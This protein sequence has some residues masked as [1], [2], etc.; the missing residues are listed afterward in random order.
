MN[1][2]ALLSRP[3]TDTATG[4]LAP[5][6]SSVVRDVRSLEQALRADGKTPPWTPPE[7]AAWRAPLPASVTFHT[8]RCAK[9][10]RESHIGEKVQGATSL[11]NGWPKTLADHRVV[12]S[13]ADPAVPFLVDLP[14]PCLYTEATCSITPGSGQ[15]NV[16]PQGRSKAAAAVRLALQVFGLAGRVDVELTLTSNIRSARGNGGSSTDIGATL[17]VVARAL[18]CEL[19]GA[20]VDFLT[21]ATERASNPSYRGP[22]IFLQRAGV[23]PWQ[24]PSW[25]GMRILGLDDSRA[26]DVVTDAMKRPRYSRGQIDAFDFMLRGLIAAVQ[27]GDVAAIGHLMERSAEI[28]E[29]FLPRNF[30]G[31]LAALREIRKQC[32]SAGVAVSH[33]GTVAALVWPTDADDVDQKVERATHALRECGYD[34]FWNYTLH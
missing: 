24:W 15:I 7:F 9:A 13:D 4:A 34:T 8:P 30:A 29:E 20:L 12:A 26:P 19:Q 21:V 6:R 1:S 3:T 33:S 32:G 11:R 31:G 23:M 27:S 22:G 10:R 5:S 16:H 2:R 14:A 17:D 25:P 18:G 28:N